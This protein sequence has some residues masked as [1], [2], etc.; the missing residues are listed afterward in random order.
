MRLLKFLQKE[1]LFGILL[2]EIYTFS[3]S[4]KDAFSAEFT[5][6]ANVYSL[7][8]MKFSRGSKEGGRK[9]ERGTEKLRILTL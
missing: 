2:R 8:S 9:N 7:L 1:V 5:T 6:F 3:G 4:K